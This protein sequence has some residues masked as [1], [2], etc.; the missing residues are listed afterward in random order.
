[1]TR[2]PNAVVTVPA[3]VRKGQVFEVRALIRHEMESGFRHTEQGIRVPRDII[4]EFTCTYNGNEV[5]RATLHPGVSANPLLI[6]YCRAEQSG[7][8]EF[9]WTGDN[10]YDAVLKK[11]VVV[12]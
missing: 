10:S 4:R 3:S 1:M 2:Q 6:F 12:T 5:F 8:L 7:D 9:R 11:S